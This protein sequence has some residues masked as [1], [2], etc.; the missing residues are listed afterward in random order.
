MKKLILFCFLMLQVSL[1]LFSQNSPEIM[2]GE[3][4]LDLAKLNVD[5]K[6]AGNMA[7]TTFE[8]F[9]YNPND[10]QLEGELSFP[11]GEGREVSRFALDIN[12]KLREAVIVEKEK[13]RVAFEST[14][15]R[16]IDPALLEKTQGN[17][18]KARIFPIEPKSYKRVV[19][20]Y[21]EKLI[22]NKG[23]LFY[24]LPLAYEVKLEEFNLKISIADVEDTSG[25]KTN[26]KFEKSG[27][28]LV[29]EINK[30]NFKLDQDFIFRIA[31]NGNKPTFVAQD[32]FFYW[33]NTIEAKERVR[34]KP[35]KIRIF[36][37]ASYSE[38][39]R[40]FQK[41]IDLLQSYFDYLINVEVQLVSFDFKA[42]HSKSFKIENG[43]AKT[44]FEFL[45]A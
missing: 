30:V 22:L 29:A 23:E 19:L 17:N 39:D 36:W 45:K 34:P 14:V 33:Y 18:Y 25:I 13:A 12:G 31:K 38:K 21:D 43:E 5:V 11:L 4:K 1:H 27:K 20:A 16:R 37:D 9:F 44:L 2:V 32:D 26:L 41:E 15:R 3:K 6:I 8:L 10:E 28:N 35:S 7:T 40:Q 42:R 24:Q